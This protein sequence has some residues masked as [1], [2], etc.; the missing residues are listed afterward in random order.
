MEGGQFP[1]TDTEKGEN[2]V[3]T[4]SFS[5][6]NSAASYDADV[7]RHSMERSAQVPELGGAARDSSLQLGALYFNVPDRRVTPLGWDMG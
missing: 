1:F 5:W 4:D 3:Y 6:D 2:R 7:T